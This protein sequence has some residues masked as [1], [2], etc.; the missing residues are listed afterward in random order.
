MH[1][2]KSAGSSVHAAL[3][4]ALAPGSLAPQRFDRSVFC[5]FEDFELLSADL[6]SQIATNAEEIGA[7]KGY[8]AVSGHF[9]LPTLLQITDARSIATVLREPRAR[10][11]SLYLYWRHPDFESLWTP[12]EANLQA[13]RPLWE[14]L[15]EPSVAPVT[16]NQIC[17]MLLYGDPRLPDSDFIAQADL[18]SIAADAI[19][20]LDSL[21]FVGV[22]ELGDGAWDGLGQSFGVTLAPTTSNVT[23][24]A[25]NPIGVATDAALLAQ[26]AIALIEQRSAADL[27]VY[28]HALA[29]AGVAAEH[30]KAL[31]DQAFAHQLVKLGDLA[32]RSATQAADHA[33]TID[34]LRS[35][36]VHDRTQWQAATT[37]HQTTI[38]EHHKT[39]RRLEGELARRDGDI[40]ELQ[41]RLTATHHSASWRLTAPLRATTRL[42]R[43]VLT[44]VRSPPTGAPGRSLLA[45]WSSNQVWLFALL[46]C[47]LIAATDAILTHVVLI[48]VLTAG[49][50]CGAFTGRWSRTA[51][52]G[53]WAFALGVPL[54]L[55]DNIW[56]TRTQFVDLAAVATVALLS[57][58]AATLAERRRHPVDL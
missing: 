36:A 43:P 18:H 54:G 37:A 1:I 53:L 42:A 10:L 6:R 51:I 14:F 29:L 38:H 32:G 50:L 46:L 58:L 57:T 20:R 34:A 9:S 19:E 7:L 40:E 5:D 12:Y 27:R 33:A 11:L 4:A 49:P 35:E 41:R 3:E 21:G 55:A 26:G 31:C 45:R 24:P 52:V 13:F 30:R 48:A 15:S 39:I 2:P 47:F 23:P 28:H 8:D 16:D 17:R 25:P 44:A 22:L 56:D